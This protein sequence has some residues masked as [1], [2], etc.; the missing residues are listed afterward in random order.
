[1]QHTAGDKVGLFPPEMANGNQAYLAA[2]AFRHSFPSHLQPPLV[3]AVWKAHPHPTAHLP[4]DHVLPSVLF[5]QRHR[6]LHH[7][8]WIKNKPG[9]KA[10]P[11]GGESSAVWAGPLRIHRRSGLWGRG[12]DSSLEVDI[13]CFVAFA[14]WEGKVFKKVALVW[15]MTATEWN[16]IYQIKVA[17][18]RTQ[19]SLQKSDSTTYNQ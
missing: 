17:Q 13:E 6:C 8:K 19:C 11:R 5:S 9:R 16:L 14:M 10:E 2:K 4:W 3:Q 15:G 7:P 12:E 1:M 18:G